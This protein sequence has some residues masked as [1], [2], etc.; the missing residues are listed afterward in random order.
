MD[1][2]KS[3]FEIPDVDELA[4]KLDEP[5]EQKYELPDALKPK[6]DVNSVI[7]PSHAVG[8][9]GETSSRQNEDFIPELPRFNSDEPGRTVSMRGMILGIC[10]IVLAVISIFFSGIPLAAN[11]INISALLCGIGGIVFG[12]VGGNQNISYGMPR[13]AMSWSGILLGILGILASG[14][15]FACIAACTDISHLFGI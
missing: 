5:V 10:S 2:N 11:I 7:N 14:I 8:P 13:G 6:T 3:R 9:N 1:E 15:S 12:A 4:R